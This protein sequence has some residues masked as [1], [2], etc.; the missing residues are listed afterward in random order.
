YPSVVGPE[1]LEVGSGRLDPWPHFRR[2]ALEDP[3]VER[4]IR[5][6]GTQ[7]NEIGRCAT[8][9]LA[10]GLVEAESGRP[11]SLIEV[12]S[13]GG[14]NLRV[15]DFDYRYA[16]DAP[17]DG[18][19]EVVLRGLAPEPRLE[20]GSRWRGPDRPPIPP[21]MP[22]IASRVGIDLEPLDLADADDARWLV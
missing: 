6:R 19:G 10:L 13:S 15:D 11:L 8:T 3:V 12:G 20:L 21:Q 14:L 7:T 22:R 5:V 9:V 18:P 16:A 2:L 17:V 4:S 1:A